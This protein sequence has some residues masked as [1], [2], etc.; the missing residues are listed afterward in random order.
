M[1]GGLFLVILVII[2]V[3]VVLRRRRRDVRRT[4]LEDPSMSLVRDEWEIDR[5][6][7]TIGKTIGEGHFGQVAYL[8]VYL[9][10]Y[11]SLSKCCD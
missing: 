5:A 6:L 3:V 9:Y 4:V 1:V 11:M 10:I 7:L 2:I 8:S